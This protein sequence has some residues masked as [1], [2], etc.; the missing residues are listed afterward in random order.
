VS[1]GCARVEFDQFSLVLLVSGPKAAETDEQQRAALQDA[2]L[3]HLATLHEAGHLLAAGPLLGGETTGF[4]GASILNV[5]ADQAQSLCEQDPAVQA[6]VF[7]VKVLPW[8]VPAGA[9]QY[10]RTRFPQSSAEAEGD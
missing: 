9:V 2:H 5:G 1:L 8:L 7:D 3:N 10:S 4:R 6:G